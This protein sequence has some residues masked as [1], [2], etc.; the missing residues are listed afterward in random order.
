MP[1]FIELGK[2]L[3]IVGGCS[4][5]ELRKFVSVI[6]AG[7]F[8]CTAATFVS[9]CFEA[10]FGAPVRSAVVLAW[11]TQSVAKGREN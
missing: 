9:V 6:I 2:V 3:E 8:C 11:R 1:F 7:P 4:A 10:W 5:V